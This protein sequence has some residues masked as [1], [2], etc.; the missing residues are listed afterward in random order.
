MRRALLTPLLLALA[1]A[2]A[3]RDARGELPELW[4]WIDADGIPRYTPDPDYVPS[5]QRGTLVRVEPGMLKAP[6][7]AHEVRPAAI[8]VPPG[9]P[10][11][12]ADP[13]NAPAPARVETEIVAPVPLEAPPR[14]AE[15]PA[16]AAPTASTAPA[17]S[18]PALTESP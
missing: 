8:F 18:A 5:A 2:V 4:R 15:A 1:L 3:A 14:A 12:E 11:L 6:E 13:F 17:V 7:P 16:T 9:E 10:P